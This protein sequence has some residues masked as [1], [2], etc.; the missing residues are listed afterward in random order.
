MVYIKI[1][2]YSVSNSSYYHSGLLSRA[3]TQSGISIRQLLILTFKFVSAQKVI[4]S[5][6][7]HEPGASLST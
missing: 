3:Q 2:M 7:M 1:V 5:I 6:C 4:E